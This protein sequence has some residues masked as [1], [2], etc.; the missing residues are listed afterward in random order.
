MET[1][2]DYLKDERILYSTK[3]G[4]RPLQYNF[5]NQSNRTQEAECP[6]CI[7]NKH[8]VEEMICENELGSRIIKNIYPIV[9]GSYGVHDVAIESYDH[10]LEF[11]DMPLE[12]VQEFLKMIQNRQRNL[13]QLDNIEYVQIFKNCGAKAGASIIHPHCQIMATNYVPSKIET[14]KRNYTKY[15]DENKTCYLCSEKDIMKIYEDD[16]AVMG[17]P[18]ANK[19]GKCFRIFTKRHIDSFSKLNSFE[20]HSLSKMLIEA[21]QLLDKLEKGVSYNIMFFTSPAKHKANEFH[22][23]VEVIERKG[24]FGGFELST[25]DYVNSTLPESVYDEIKNLTEV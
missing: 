22:F 4:K 25:G 13:E 14:I 9:D 1:R 18:S 19:A 3:R 11:K 12:L 20:L 8:L 15:N 10:E 24:N 7:G 21:T 6:F 23:F 2:I 16:F 17:I 5:N